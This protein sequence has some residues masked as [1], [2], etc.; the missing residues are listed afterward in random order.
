MSRADETK[1]IKVQIP[2]DADVPPF[3]ATA[4]PAQ[5]ALAL[6]LG[7]EA[8]THLQR[9]ALEAVR[10]ETHAEAVKQATAEFEEQLVAAEKEAA[11]E[12]TKLRTQA[13]R[14][15][16][17]L[18]VAQARLEVLE[19]GSAMTRTEAHKEA[20]A[21]AGELLAAKD[22]QIR[23]LQ[24]TLE[25]QLEAMTTK[26]EALQNSMTKTFS[27]SKEKGQFGEA[28]M[29]GF[30]KKAF[31]CDVQIVSKDP[32]TADLRMTRASGAT[33]FWESKNYTRMVNP[34]EVEKFRRD[35]RLHPDVRGGVLVSLRTGIIGKGRG[36]DIDL[37]FLEDGRPVV[38]LSHFMAR[39]D[40][41]FALQSLRPLL[42]VVETLSRPQ[43]EDSE[44]V[45]ALEAKAT[46][47]TT[48]LRSHAAN[49]AKHK[50]AVATHRKRTESM[51]A[52][53]SAYLTEATTQLQTVLTVAIGGEDAAAEVAAD[54]EVLLNP[55]VFRLEKL[56]D[57]GEERTRE[58]LKRLLDAVE[59]RDGTQMELKELVSWGK[60]RGYGDKWVRD[61]R[62]TLFQETAWPKGARFLMGLRW[63]G[64]N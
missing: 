57:I 36:G 1:V 17:A 35:L 23:Q 42:D 27:S 31:D 9:R 25:R 12:A 50:N 24:T 64:E 8:V 60:E 26:V 15:E 19:T 46:L 6:K 63:R 14:A 61:L 5:R 4:A 16:E 43:K 38:F 34:E 39:E 54:A 49:V 45:R 29:E 20:R 33:Y 10:Q 48:L 55:L 28:L 21:A 40:P 44:A 51:F 59:I 11:R 22:A 37:E 32:Q 13:T 47:I 18:R 56:H 41:V 2:A 53:F 3:Y 52:E 58:F 30:L 62:E 7:A